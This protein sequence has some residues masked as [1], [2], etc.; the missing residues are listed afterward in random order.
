M[1][2]KQL[3]DRNNL[4]THMKGHQKAIAP[5]RVALLESSVFLREK[6]T[7]NNRVIEFLIALERS[8]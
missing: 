5:S 7:T 6:L 4:H 3:F 8:S 2:I 1:Y